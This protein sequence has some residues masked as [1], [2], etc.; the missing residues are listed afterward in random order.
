MIIP[1]HNSSQPSPPD[2]EELTNIF[3]DEWISDAN[4]EYYGTSMSNLYCKNSPWNYYTPQLS[5]SRHHTVLFEMP[6]TLIHPPKPHYTLNASHW[7]ANHVRMPFSRKNIFPVKDSKKTV[8]KPRW[9]IIKSSLSQPIKTSVQLEEAVFS[10][11]LRHRKFEALHHFFEEVFDEEESKHFFHTLLPQIIQLALQLPELIQTPLPLLKQGKPHTISLSQLQIASLLANAF[12]CTF[13]WKKECDTYPGINFNRLYECLTQCEPSISEKLKC[14]IHYFRCVCN[15]TP[16][17]VVTF[18]RKHLPRT[19]LPRWD[20]N[21]N[22][23]G[24]IK[25][26]ITHKGTIENDGKGCLQVDFANCMVGGG[27]LGYGCVQEEIRFAIC[28][29]LLVSRLFTEQLNPN[30]ALLI[31]GAQCY[32]E[33]TGYADTFEWA[34]NHHD[35]TPYDEYGRRRTNI[36]AIDALL[37]FNTAVQFRPSKM[38]REL[39]KAYVGFHELS[40]AP[41]SLLSPVATG[42]WG[43]GAFR[44]NHHLKALMQLMACAAARRNIVYYTFGAKSLQSDVFHIYNFLVTNR[45]TVAQLWRYLGHFNETGVSSRQLLPFIKQAHLDS[46]HSFINI[47]ESVLSRHCVEAQ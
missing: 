5:P 7:D 2:T 22:N 25:L 44:G 14:F 1:L 43:C 28:P 19:Q 32:S 27:V 33:Y 16:K 45:V 15:N 18:E 36:L 35:E 10:Y 31:I 47:N 42:N 39:N 24:D 17:G 38:I 26:H 9:D 11:N 13:P 30:E 40:S 8:L 21:E 3:G 41:K 29:E 23:I 20:K 34:G 12:L 46:T 37:Y 6:A 4:D